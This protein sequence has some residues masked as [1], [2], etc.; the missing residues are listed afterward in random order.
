MGLQR[1]EFYEMPVGEFL[2]ALAAYRRKEAAERRHTGELARGAA[3]R[4]FNIQLR[5]KDQIRKPSDFWAMPWDDEDGATAAP[6]RDGGT[7]MKDEDGRRS[8]ARLLAR[9][10]GKK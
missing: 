7:P 6:E 2:E 3:L 8:L 5:R 4:L 10:N 9:L 1:R